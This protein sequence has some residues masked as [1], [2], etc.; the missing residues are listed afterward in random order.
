VPTDPPPTATAPPPTEAPPPSA[1]YELVFEATWSADS[2][3]A[4]F[5]PNPHFSPLIGASHGPDANLWDVE[6]PASPGIKNVAETGGTSPLDSE[7]EAFIASGTACATIS[8]GGVPVSPGS[9]SVTFTVNLGCPLVSVVTMIAPSPDWF[10]GVAG[11]NLLQDGAWVDELT[12]ELLPHDAGTDSGTRYTS[13]NDPTSSPGPITPIEWEPL[14]VDGIVPALGT[15]TFT[16][17][18]G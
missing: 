6:N 12:I 10:V 3:P 17:L 2:H 14:V 15:F 5:P 7:I 16:R 11:L 9:V 18:D 1:K 4:D 8:G 13:P